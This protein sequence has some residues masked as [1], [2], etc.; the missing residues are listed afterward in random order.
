V[1]PSPA[2]LIES[3]AESQAWFEG[4][5]PPL[6]KTFTNAGANAGA[7]LL[8]AGRQHPAASLELRHRKPAPLAEGL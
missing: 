3:I 7:W 8:E 2:F 5:P 1:L 6:E 4:T